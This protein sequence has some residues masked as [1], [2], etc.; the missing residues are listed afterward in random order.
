MRR[1]AAD[2]IYHLGG[3]EQITAPQRIYCERLAADLLKIELIERRVVD[4]SATHF[5]MVVLHA[6]RNT[7]RLGLRDLGIE[8]RPS[9][10]VGQGADV[11]KAARATK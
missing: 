1:T 8:S 10:H 11:L 4:G 6:L 9:R 5:D 7:T 3:P 2:L